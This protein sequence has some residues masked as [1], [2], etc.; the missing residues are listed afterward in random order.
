MAK[1]RDNKIPED[2]RVYINRERNSI[3]IHDIKEKIIWIRPLKELLNS[4]KIRNG[5][6]NK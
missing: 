1:H 6:N 5:K 4:N 3:E 2:F